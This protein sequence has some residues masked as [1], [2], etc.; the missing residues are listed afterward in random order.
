MQIF[1]IFITFSKIDLFFL[2]NDL[3]LAIFFFSVK[4]LIFLLSIEKDQLCSKNIR[5]YKYFKIG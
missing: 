1:E 4:M 3:K 2:D 5:V